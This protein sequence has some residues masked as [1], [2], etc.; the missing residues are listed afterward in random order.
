MAPPNERPSGGGICS[1]ATCDKLPA[2][3]IEFRVTC[4]PF[5]I[6]YLVLYYQF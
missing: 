5:K 3:L 4:K 2:F 6:A 1:Q